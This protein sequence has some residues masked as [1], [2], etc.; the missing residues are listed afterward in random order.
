LSY[1]PEREK[2][3][4]C[5][6]WRRNIEPGFL[7]RRNE[8]GPLTAAREA[9]PTGGSPFYEA[10]D[11]YGDLMAFDLRDVSVIADCS[12]EAIVANDRDQEEEATYKKTHGEE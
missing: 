1:R 11:I 2:A 6:V 4:Y 7:L 10:T 3:G 5:K 9:V 12:P 8:Y